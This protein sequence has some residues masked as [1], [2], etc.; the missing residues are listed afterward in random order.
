MTWP[1]AWC[2]NFNFWWSHVMF[3]F[4]FFWIFNSRSTHLLVSPPCR[5]PIG[6]CD[7]VMTC[8]LYLSYS[9]PY[10]IQYCVLYIFCVIVCILLIVFHRSFP[11][12]SLI[13]SRIDEN[14]NICSTYILYSRMWLLGKMGK[15]FVVIQDFQN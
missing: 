3:N 2:H 1:H 15:S 10:T 13:L 14:I 6:I 7:D 9:V 8:A 5:L 11:C 12:H 4:Q